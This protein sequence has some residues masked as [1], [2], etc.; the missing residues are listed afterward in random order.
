[1]VTC[2]FW[3]LCHYGYLFV[4]GLLSLVQLLYVVLLADLE[5]RDHGGGCLGD[6]LLHLLI[7][8]VFAELGAEHALFV[9]VDVLQP[10][11]ELAQQLLHAVL[12]PVVRV[13]DVGHGVRLL[14]S[15]HTQRA[16]KQLTLPA[17]VADGLLVLQAKQQLRLA[18]GDVDG[19][20]VLEER[21][22]V[23]YLDALRAEA[24]VAAGAVELGEVGLFVLEFAEVA[25]G[26]VALDGHALKHLF[27]FTDLEI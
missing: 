10:S 17:E 22:L 4:L 2:L 3:A 23:V 24:L 20:V 12:V 25:S 19:L 16:Q 8:A 27:E 6:Q 7:V 1:M 26:I 11:V 14:V 13:L 9:R 18:L 15:H 21:V 5:L